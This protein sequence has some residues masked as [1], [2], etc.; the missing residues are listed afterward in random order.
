MRDIII[1]NLYVLDCTVFAIVKC[2]NLVHFCGRFR[3]YFY[4]VTSASAVLTFSL[5]FLF[6]FPE[7]NPNSHISVFDYLLLNRIFVWFDS[8]YY[9]MVWGIYFV[10]YY[11]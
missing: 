4:A 6:F 9:F 8:N 10:Q 1:C 2:L 7:K 5:S 3:F 11:W